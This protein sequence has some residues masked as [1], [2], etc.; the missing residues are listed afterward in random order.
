MAL[1]LAL[2]LLC[3]TTATTGNGDKPRIHSTADDLLVRSR[4]PKK[5]PHDVVPPD[6]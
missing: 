1:S 5:E 4:P 6:F 3:A 2:A